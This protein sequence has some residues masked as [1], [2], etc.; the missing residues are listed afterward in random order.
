MKS[1]VYYGVPFSKATT[2][3][4]SSGLDR[5]NKLLKCT[6]II[7]YFKT[8]KT[9]HF[10]HNIDKLTPNVS[11]SIVYKYILFVIMSYLYSGSRLVGTNANSPFLIHVILEA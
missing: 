11:S 7:P 6:E 8:F 1:K 10:Y 4:I 9:Q 3:L 2:K 5:K